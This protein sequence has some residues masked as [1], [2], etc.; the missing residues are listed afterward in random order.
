M[1][2]SISLSTDNS[3]IYILPPI[4]QVKI[5]V[6]TLNRINIFISVK[7]SS[8]Q[9]LFF[10]PKLYSKGKK[11]ERGGRQGNLQMTNS[12]PGNCNKKSPS[13][14]NTSTTSV[15]IKDEPKIKIPPLPKIWHR[16]QFANTNFDKTNSNQLNPQPKSSTFANK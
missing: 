10:P 16:N 13:R 7:N 5:Y 6:T 2:A 14:G 4:Y 1:E 9:E 12:H 11:H 3:M 15:N 8:K